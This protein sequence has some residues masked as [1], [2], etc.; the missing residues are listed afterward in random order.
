MDE[1]ER[2]SREAA[3]A[4]S[5][6]KLADLEA[7]KPLWEQAA[8]ARE[9]R[10]RAEEETQRAL[11][12]ERKKA[13]LRRE[14]EER[15]ARARDEEAA[16]AGREEAERQER[17]TAARRTRARRQRQDRWY[18]TNWSTAHALARYREVSEAFEEAKFTAED[19]VTFDS[20]PWPIL[21]APVD[22]SVEDID[23]ASVER[24]F[25]AVEPLMR[26][27]EYKTF[28]EKSQRRFHPDRW[29]SRNVL[30][31]VADESERACLG[32]GQYFLPYRPCISC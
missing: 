6:R 20:V 27:S 29:R 16:A 22:L 18:T 15:L 32:V 25:S 13:K 1:Q 31:S 9:A 3:I 28:V 30:K 14:A 4:E 17:E 11:A 24:F 5:R 19:P 8:R 7:D 12:E 2:L 23:W 21:K 10:E 26:T